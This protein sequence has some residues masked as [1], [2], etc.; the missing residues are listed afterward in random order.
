ML[1]ALAAGGAEGYFVPRML[2][3]A[4]LSLVFA[5]SVVVRRPLVGYIIG[6]LYRAAVD[7]L[8]PEDP[9]VFSEVTLAWS[10]LFAFRAIVYAVLIAAA[11]RR[12]GW[13]SQRRDGLAGV[14]APA[15]RLY[16]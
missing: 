14:P 12:A 8:P 9:R 4:A 13:R 16:R 15:V 1:I 5:G 2:Y 7:G 3:A 10:G 11:A 6:G